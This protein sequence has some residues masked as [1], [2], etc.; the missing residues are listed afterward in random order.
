MGLLTIGS[1]PTRWTSRILWVVCAAAVLAA[2]LWLHEASFSA[3]GQRGFLG[4]ISRWMRANQV[5]ARLGSRGQEFLILAFI[6]VP[7]QIFL[8]AVKRSPKLLTA[9]FQIDLFF[10][11]FSGVYLRIIG[12][13]ALVGI[14]RA[15][16]YGRDPQ[17]VPFLGELPFVAQVVLYTWAHD[18]VVY[19]RHR[20]EHTLGFFW[21]FHATHHS[22]ERV[23]FLTTSRLHPGERFFGGILSGALA[24]LAFQREAAALGFSIYIYWNYF[25][26]ANV[27]IK[28]P[29]FLK[30]LLVSPFMHQW[31]HAKDTEAYGKNVGV[32][33]AWNDWLFRTIYYP[34]H[35]ATD[36]GLGDGEQAGV[37]HNPLRH[38]LYP[39]RYWA[40]RYR[41]WREQHSPTSVLDPDGTH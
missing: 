38:F 10:Y 36:F 26:H 22:A 6:A 14:V 39:F 21:A 32:V 16:V 4:D 35:W 27:K 24:A 9:E 20:V 17:W 18:F 31:H 30:Y 40:R 28:F 8:P 33:F 29:G 23:D 1:G 37:G 2:V 12:F 41:I 15:F 3:S 5:V 25:I 19:W 7:L 13:Y 11:W 34:N